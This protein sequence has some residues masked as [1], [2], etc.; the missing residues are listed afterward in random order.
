MPDHARWHQIECPACHEAIEVE[1]DLNDRCIFL[2][3]ECGQQG[4]L[5]LAVEWD[6]KPMSVEVPHE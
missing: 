2:E 6:A 3:C 4:S 1:V 5:A